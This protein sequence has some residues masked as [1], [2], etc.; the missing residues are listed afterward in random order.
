MATA[1]ALAIATPCAPPAANACAEAVAM[2]C[3]AA[4]PSVRVKEFHQRAS[5]YVQPHLTS[6]MLLCYVTSY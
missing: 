3:A 2:A 5:C 4:P 1:Y 6:C